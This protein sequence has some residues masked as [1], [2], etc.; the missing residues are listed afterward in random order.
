VI[1]LLTDKWLESVP[2]LQLLCLAGVLYPLHLINLNLLQAVGR[3]DLFLRLE[4][5]KKV[6]VVVNIAITWQW[7]IRAMLYGVIVYSAIAYYLNCRYTGDLIGYP[8]REQLHDLFPYFI[9]A[10]MM[11]IVIYGVGLLPFPNHWSML[12]IQITAGVFI[13]VCLCRLLRLSAFTELWHMTWN[14]L[15]FWSGTNE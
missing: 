14:R 6:L 5:I 10:T 3:S 13:Y 9:I 11:S 1:V 2:Y 15:P 7:G 8:L 4:I 12:L